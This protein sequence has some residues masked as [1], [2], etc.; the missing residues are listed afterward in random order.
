MERSTRNN[1]P[2]CWEGANPETHWEE[3]KK[4]T[5][6]AP[7]SPKKNAAPAGLSPEYS[8][9]LSRAALAVGLVFL[10]WAAVDHFSTDRKPKRHSSPGLKAIAEIKVGQRVVAEIPSSQ[11]PDLEFGEEV[12]PPNWRKLVLRAPKEDGSW[13]D[14]ALLRPNW[15]LEE[16]EAEVGKNVDID[17]PECGISGPALV[18]AIEP[19]PAIPSG[20]GRV[21][22]GTFKHHSATVTDVYVEGLSSP[23]GTTANHLFW[24]EDR[25]GFCRADELRPGEGLKGVS[26]TLRVLRSETRALTEPVYNLDVQ[27]AHV[28]HVSQA[29]IL[30]HNSN[31]CPILLGESMPNRVIQVAKEIGARYYSPRNFNRTNQIRWI[32][33]QIQSRRPIFDIGRDARRSARSE[34]YAL[35][36]KYLADAGYVRVFRRWVTDANGKR[37]RLYEWVPPS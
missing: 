6:T 31:L 16:Q 19:C 8:K 18:L 17:V 4:L 29:G 1:A 26:K 10:T 27:L 20:K 9:W 37:Y 2:W 13:A 33:R 32:R 35:E 34:W 30:V 28:Y 5:L 36:V 11:E 25:K 3:R 12:D 22:T 15:W 23:I 21:V 24:S 14:V 7:S